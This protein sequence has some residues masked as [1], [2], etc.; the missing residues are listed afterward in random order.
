MQTCFW[1]L[2]GCGW[3]T[4]ICFPH[5]KE[6][7]CTAILQILID[8]YEGCYC[9]QHTSFPPWQILIQQFYLPGRLWVSREGYLWNRNG[10]LLWACKFSAFS[11]LIFQITVRNI[12]FFCS[13]HTRPWLTQ[14]T[15]PQYSLSLYFK[16]KFLRTH[17]TCKLLASSWGTGHA[18]EVFG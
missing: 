7:Q 14:C 2:W 4:Y 17:L 3:K 5:R 8:L 18:E 6:K 12:S 10:R 9:E 11:S 16:N 1:T 15:Y 13:C